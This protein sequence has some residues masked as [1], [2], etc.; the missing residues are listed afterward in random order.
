VLVAVYT[1]RDPLKHGRVLLAGLAAGGVFTAAT[2]VL[3]YFSLMP[4]AW[5]LFTEFGRARALFKDPNVYGPFMLPGLLWCAHIFIH[6]SWRGSMVAMVCLPVLLAGLLVSFSRGAWLN[7]ATAVAVYGCLAFVMADT[8]RMRIRL[9]GSALA[10]LVLAGIAFAAVLQVPEVLD[11]LKER[12]TLLQ[13][14]DAGPTGRFAGQA[15]A[16]SLIAQHPLGIGALEFSSSHHPE[17]V[18]NVYLS[19]FLNAGWLGGFLYLGAVLVTLAAGLRA[20]LVSSPVQ[21][22]LMVAVASFAG[23]VFEGLV[24]DSDHWRHFYVVMGLIWGLLAAVPAR[25]TE[26]RRR[27]SPGF[28]R[29]GR[30]G[31]I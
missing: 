12:A 17:D 26:V 13:D 28:S 27:P 30:S 22:L 10:G 4:G 7:A 15:K 3:G 16:L 14:Y 1:A 11:F 20:C 25:R 5:D 6:G 8:N 9:A 31:E 29:S 2:G 18:H 23:L 24:I 19:M 21:G